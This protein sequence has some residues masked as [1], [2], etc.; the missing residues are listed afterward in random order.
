M[1]SLS[2]AKIRDPTNLAEQR[3]LFFQAQGNRTPIFSYKGGRTASE[4]QT[5]YLRR[6]GD[7]HTIS[8]QLLGAATRVIERALKEHGTEDGFERAR[9]GTQ[10]VR[11]SQGVQR[12]LRAC[13]EAHGLDKRVRIRLDREG[14]VRCGKVAPNKS[15]SEMNRREREAEEKFA[16][17]REAKQEA[18]DA[19][20]AGRDVWDGV[21]SEDEDDAAAK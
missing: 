7:I 14:G 11:G 5:A 8:D 3:R 21:A 13:L 17:R 2:A 15:K 18:E 10:R 16:R 9:L 1:T 20:R 19:R 4:V 6:S 12:I